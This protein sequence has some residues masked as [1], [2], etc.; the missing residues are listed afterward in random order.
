VLLGVLLDDPEQVRA[1]F[2]SLFDVLKARL[3]QGAEGR[4]PLRWRAATLTAELAKEV[5][6]PLGGHL[7]LGSDA[8]AHG[9]SASLAA[10][11]S[12]S[13]KSLNHCSPFSLPNT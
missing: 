12:A 11:D 2:A 5:D 1:V 9:E 4:H 10:T 8:G 6:D 7:V 13:N 3:A